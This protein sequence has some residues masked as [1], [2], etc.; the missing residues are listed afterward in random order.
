MSLITFIVRV[1]GL[2]WRFG[3]TK[4]NAVIA[5]ARNNWPRVQRMLAVQGLVSTVE[6]ILRLLGY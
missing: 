3:R 6:A 2:V 5:F 1:G 4:I